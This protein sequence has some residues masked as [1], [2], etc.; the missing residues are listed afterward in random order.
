MQNRILL[1]RAVNHVCLIMAGIVSCS[2]AVAPAHAEF[3]DELFKLTG[4]DSASA[5]LGDWFGNAVAINEN[6][7]VVGA[8]PAGGTVSR[9]FIPP[10][11]AYVYDRS[12]GQEVRKLTGS[13]VLPFD[14]FGSAVA[15]SGNIA[16]IGAHTKNDVG[17]S[18]G[19]AYVFDVTTGQELW[20]LTA[21][22]AAE[23][24]LFGDAVATNGT[25]AIIGA[26]G[27]G[28]DGANYRYDGAAYLFDVATGQET[29]K[30]TPSD[31]AM[32]DKF[33]SAVAINHNVAVVGAYRSHGF[34][35]DY[36]KGTAYAFDIASGQEL[37]KVT[38]SD[39]VAGDAF[40]YSLA[41][42]GN[43]A[44]VGA[45]QTATGGTGAAY[46][47]DVRT[48]QELR[49]V[50]PLDSAAT[51]Q[52]G[53]SVA[54]S[55]NT[56]IVGARTADNLGSAYLFDVTTGRELAKILPS[57]PT[58]DG[59]F[60]YSLAINGDKAIVGIPGYQPC[61]QV[62]RPP[63][64][65]YVF[66]VARG[67][68]L[69]GDF[70]NDGTVNAADYAVWR[71]GL[72]TSYTQADYNTWRANFGRSAASAATVGSISS[73][74]PAVPEPITY[75]LSATAVL[76]LN[77]ARRRRQANELALR[78]PMMENRVL[79]NRT[80]NH[81]CLIVTGIVTCFA[82]TPAHAEFG[83]LLFRLSP[84]DAASVNFFGESVSISSTTAVIGAPN[85]S[86]SAGSAY[87]F[88]VTTGQQL[89]RLAASDGAPGDG[90]G[91]DV[92]IFGNTALVGAWQSFN[93]TGSKFGKAY[94]FDVATGQELSKLMA[95]DAVP[96][97]RFGGGVALFGNKAVVSAQSFTETLGLSNIHAG[98]AYVF[99]VSSSQQLRKYTP[100]DGVPGDRFG[101]SIGQGSIAVSGDIAI[102][103]AR[104][105][106]DGGIIDSGAAYLFDV[107]TGQELFKLQPSDPQE[108]DIFGHD[109]AISGNKALVGASQQFANH[110]APYGAAYL[111]DVTTGQQLFKFAPATAYATFGW[112]VAL[113]S[114][115]ALVGARDEGAAYLFDVE[116][117]K[118]L[119]RLTG[120]AGCPDWPRC[121]FGSSVA[122]NDNF[123]VIGARLENGSQGAAYVFDI[124]RGPAL[125]GDFNNDGT[126]DAADYAVWR[127]GLG[128]TYTQADYNAWRTNF[129]RSATGAAAGADRDVN[130]AVPEPSALVLIASAVAGLNWG[131]RHQLRRRD[132][133]RPARAIVAAFALCLLVTGSAQASLHTYLNIADNTTAAPTGV[134]SFFNA[135]SISGGTVAFQG[136][137]AGGEGIF[138]G[139]GGAL[140]TIAK[141]GDPAPPG[142]TFTGLH[143]PAIDGGT[144]A[145]RAIF[146]G[147]HG[148]FTGS[149]GALNT[150]AK[151]GDTA[152]PGG[153]FHF[154]G[155]AAID[156]G[157]VAFRGSFA[158][159]NGIF[160]GSGGALTTIGKSGDPAPPG[161]TFTGFDSNAI[162]GG[163]VAFRGGYA[164]GSGIFTD[165][166]G[167]LTT[168]AKTGDPAPPGGTF[169]GL[170]FTAIDGG[171]VALHG[172]YAGGNGIF[173]GSGGALTTI[174]KSG[175]PAPPGT[176]FTF[177]NIAA[178]DSG[179]V[180]FQGVYAGGEGIFTDSGGT[181]DTV[182]K[183][184]DSLFGSMVTDLNFDRFGLDR[185]GSGNL[186]FGYTLAD[187]RNGVAVAVASVPEASAWLTWGVLF[188]AALVAGPLRKHVRGLFR[189][190]SPDF[191]SN[192]SHV[193]RHEPVRCTFDI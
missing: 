21:S 16:I 27:V 155:T 33:G 159:A 65:A 108:K 62:I 153:A 41:V 81:V 87:L 39:A 158:G 99:D 122:M 156:G 188:T 48:G 45:P 107:T 78:W 148:I 115:T 112:S 105:K 146:A 52:L 92:A 130:G 75:V 53:V 113:N 129:G 37:F 55:G 192:N 44:I 181:L 171:T 20:K 139:S 85:P 89:R 145:F 10:G 110:D 160:T 132:F 51:D 35:P 80:I 170:D 32:N 7:I 124:S 173:T 119:K 15:L 74:V 70:N 13:D 174:V 104:Y 61:C 34:P 102:G 77:G 42:D 111:F 178:I 25:T 36:R 121:Q 73:T 46:L 165:T 138:T 131:R 90:F 184:G 176:T 94:L 23:G 76:S 98:A 180:A 69:L 106:D 193:P 47:F 134:F 83:D 179:T 84:T 190:N 58:V 118:L 117:G 143:F 152:P 22:D 60:G 40:G 168:I 24:D 177:F 161:G 64:S 123:A 5:P 172:F 49:K 187:G 189:H 127:N 1:K 6:L 125:P 68:A 29:H 50:T 116:T 71:N 9:P 17:N 14:G 101:G 8:A 135:P 151:T 183:T 109:V 136:V 67:P 103:G 144:V 79:V 133:S 18:S 169:T 96:E 91:K 59:Q 185:D 126:V 97:D 166:G 26:V 12:T 163:T 54:I 128:T 43:I 28:I 186:A 57:A 164:G 95:S 4:S 142:G 154:I 147:G 141:S 66:D 120:P 3:G 140:T 137:Y 19:A 175:D 2:A 30:L 63:G 191:D 162:D 167:A 38:A 149:G 31:A 114:T 182:I 100:S 82:A 72:G 93:N 86:T 150:I 157:T 11:V 88:D 56:A